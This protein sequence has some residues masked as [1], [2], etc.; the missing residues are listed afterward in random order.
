MGGLIISLFLTI[1]LASQ[2]R[3]RHRS[4]AV[5]EVRNSMNESDIINQANEKEN[6]L[7]R[8]K[9]DRFDSLDVDSIEM[10]VRRSR[11]TSATIMPLEAQVH[12]I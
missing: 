8:G 1:S 11:P 6:R 9:V 12:R 5:R 7:S 3:R 10:N 4:D 2:Q